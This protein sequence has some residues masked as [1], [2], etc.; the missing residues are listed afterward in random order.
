MQVASFT[1][2]EF[3]ENTYIL[4]DDTKQCAIIDPGCYKASEQ[5]QLTEFIESNH[6]TPILLIN[7][8]C[9]IDHVLGN[10][11]VANKYNLALHLHQQE[12]QTYEDTGRWAQFFGV[13]TDDIPNK[14]VYITEGDTLQFGN[15]KLDVL[16]T[17][18]HSVASLSFFHEASK[19]LISGDV[20][21]Y[22]SI[23]RTDL[24]NGDFNTLT[25]SIR[26]KLFTLPDDTK[27]YS[28]HGPVTS[29]GHEKTHNPFLQ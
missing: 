5:K 9:H 16:F 2:N 20:L 22:E 11:F 10:S 1:F 15:T 18:G 3:Q 26:T 21:F 4:F 25:N 13:V 29:I 8:H 27:V 23:G 6:L 12:L 28:G 24:P 17:P 19:Q 14:Q 7:T